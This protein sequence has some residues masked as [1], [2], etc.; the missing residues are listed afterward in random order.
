MENRQDHYPK[1]LALAFWTKHPQEMDHFDNYFFYQ[2]KP[3]GNGAASPLPAELAKLIKGRKERLLAIVEKGSEEAGQ[4]A[5]AISARIFN[6]LVKKGL[7]RDRLRKTVETEDFWGCLV[8]YKIG[9]EERQV[10]FCAGIDIVA[11]ASKSDPRLEIVSWVWASDDPEHLQEIL[12]LLRAP[13]GQNV[14]PATNILPS[15]EPG[16]IVLSRTPIVPASEDWSLNFL[17]LVDKAVLPFTDEYLSANT[18]GELVKIANRKR[19][20]G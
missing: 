8:T 18:I 4:L 14:C 20:V 9:Q 10:K 16:T 17:Q 2:D 11:L 7:V 5:E 6:N 15:W 13:S 12:D 3:T 19:L 1:L